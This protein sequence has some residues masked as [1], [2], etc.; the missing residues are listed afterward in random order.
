MKIRRLRLT[1][2]GSL[3]FADLSRSFVYQRWQKAYARWPNLFRMVEERE[4]A[5]YRVP[6][7]ELQQGLPSATV[8]LRHFVHVPP[9]WDAVRGK[10]FDLLGEYT[11]IPTAWRVRLAG[12][13]ALQAWLLP[14]AEDPLR[15]TDIGRALEALGIKPLTAQDALSLVLSNPAPAYPVCAVGS[16]FL[17]EGEKYILSCE[18]DENSLPIVAFRRELYLPKEARI[19]VYAL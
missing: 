18:L 5:V 19:P 9:N 10:C 11:L 14:F 1:R 8:L 7:Q 13:D 16:V 15:A 6:L 4:L 3:A 12:V 17:I 2:V